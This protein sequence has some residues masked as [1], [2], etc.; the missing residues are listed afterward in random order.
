[1]EPSFEKKEK[2]V[3]VFMVIVLVV[4]LGVVGMVGRARDWFRSYAIYYTVFDEAYNL[5]RNARVKLYTVDVGKVRNVALEGD[6]VKVELAV[7][8]DYAPRIRK[9]SVATVESPT[10]I[11]SEYVSIRPGTLQA[12]PIPEGGT[13]ASKPKKSIADLMA[14]FEVQKTAKMIIKSIQAITAIVEHLKDPKGPLFRALASTADSMAH[15]EAVTRKIHEGRGSLGKL[16]SSEQ[17]LNTVYGQLNKVQRILNQLDSATTKA[18]EITQNV[19]DASART[20]E[21]MNQIQD[22]LSTVK[23]ILDHIEKGSR[24]IPEVTES[25]KRGVKELREGL[26]ELDKVVRSLQQNFFVKRH[27]RPEA[28]GDKMDMGLRR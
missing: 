5:S 23:Q 7:L 6:K 14:E 15:I 19:Q 21:I 18:D 16:V 27:L 12:A 25:T 17:L 9:D 1:M 3:G 8:K 10:V 28:E 4:L 26:E 22:S 11:G 2:L 13:I 24:D 20:P